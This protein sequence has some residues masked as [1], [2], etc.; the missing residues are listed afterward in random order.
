MRLNHM[1]GASMGHVTDASLATSCDI[2]GNHYGDRKVKMTRLVTGALCRPQQGSKTRDGT[3]SKEAAHRLA[4][5]SRVTPG[6]R[7]F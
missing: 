1:R 3:S 4:A 2:Y 5:A 7:T 6:A